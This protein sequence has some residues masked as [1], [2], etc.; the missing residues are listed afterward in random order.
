MKHLAAPAR[1]P[2]GAALVIAVLLAALGLLL[3]VQGAGIEEKGG[4][5]GVGSGD[6]PRFLGYGMMALAAA[7]V[8]SAFRYAGGAVMRPQIAPVLW[9]VAGLTLQ[10]LLLRPLG[11][12]IAS[13]LLFAFTAAGFGKRNLALTIPMGIGLSLAIYGVFD[14]LLRLRLPAGFLE[15]LIF[16]A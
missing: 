14:Q 5:A 3:V 1:R 13:G 10:V 16:G 12:S 7:H 6:L 4:Y 9:V 11:F 2:D 15:T 8:F